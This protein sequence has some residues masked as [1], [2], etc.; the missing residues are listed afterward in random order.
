MRYIPYLSHYIGIQEFYGGMSSDEAIGTPASFSYSRALDHRR[1][2]SQLTVLPGPRKISA[3]VVT[4]LI[5]NMAQV[6]S[7]NRYACGD[8][9][10]IYKIDTSNVVT[11]V[12]KL[13]T[14]SDGML[15]RSDNDNLYFAT[16]TEVYRYSS[17]SGTA[18]FDVTY[19]TSRSA[20]TNAYRTGGASTYNVPQLAAP[21]ESQACYFQ[22]DIEPFYS[23]KVN[24]KTI[25]TGNV[26]LI[27]HDGLNNN[28]GQ[29]TIPNG[30]LTVGL[31]E[32]VFSSQIRALVKPNARTYHWHIVS[33][34]TDTVI[35][36]GT[37]GTLNTAD[38][39]LWAYRLIDTIN[40]LHPMAQ[41]QQF[42][43][44]GNGNYLAVWEPLT[45]K[46]PPNSE[47]QRHKLTFPSGFEV[48]GLAVTDEFLVIACAKYS[49]DGTKDFQEGKLFTWDGTAATYNQVV[50]VSGGAP[51][52]TKTH[53]NIPYF[54]VNGKLCA[55]PGG[56]D[57]VQVRK[58][59]SLDN[60][61]NG[62]IDNTR[63]YPNMLTVKDNMLHVGFPS[64]TTNTAVEYGTYIW[65]SLEKNF[66]DSFNYAYVPNAM[67]TDPN[68]L[69]TSGNLQQGCVKS[70]GDEMYLSWKDKDN[71]YGLDIVDNLCTPA[72]VFK[73]RARRFDGGQAYRDKLA[74]KVG[75][76]TAPLP[77]GVTMTAVTSING[78]VYKNGLIHAVGG[79]R[80]ISPI[81]K[82]SGFKRIVTGFDGACS[83]SA[84]TPIIY[85]EILE[86]KPLETE[87][88]L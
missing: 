7:G 2:P 35:V 21:D 71:N 65:G 43:C 38:Y 80:L 84:T 16:Q 55:W 76:A 19:G 68:N 33:S 28:L 14:G 17:N 9:G 64:R 37:S 75:V 15:Y 27:L 53:N 78:A 22:P 83:T 59:A 49:S 47:F 61:F 1:N 88:S 67:A 31:N 62:T 60:T 10:M 6:K 63:V 8:T 34:Q 41:F 77:A 26:T 82:P 30:S 74:L 70:F 58:I 18:L 57:I 86:Y 39:E 25:G 72:P 73:F 85:S 51:E 44:I 87:F 36:A 50:D 11:Y 69:N 45:D 40:N 81:D 29:V 79:E 52:G 32:F 42:T 23:I 12:G 46:D 4:D 20:D 54:V 66:P 56:K 48:C 13:P 24:I 3:G 5:L